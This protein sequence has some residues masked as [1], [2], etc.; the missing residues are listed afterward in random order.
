MHI[1]S[2][3][4]AVFVLV[5]TLVSAAL[6]MLLLYGALALAVPK[7]FNDIAIGFAGATTVL[8]AG[9]CLQYFA[10]SFLYDKDDRAELQLFGGVRFGDTVVEAMFSGKGATWPFAKLSATRE[11]LRLQTP[12]GNYAWGRADPRPIIQKTGRS[13]QWKI[14]AEDTALTRPI[15]RPIVFSVFPRRTKTIE[16]KLKAL[17]YEVRPHTRS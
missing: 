10:K 3:L 16:R 7:N 14:G 17:G 12:F 9:A 1:V 6:F 4:K 5:L 2:Y 13:G 8:F 15:A 11:T